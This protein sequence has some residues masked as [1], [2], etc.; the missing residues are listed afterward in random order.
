MVKNKGGEGRQDGLA[1]ARWRQGRC[2]SSTQGDDAST[3]A[4]QS[5]DVPDGQ[6]VGSLSERCAG[7][8]SWQ[9]SNDVDIWRDKS[10][11]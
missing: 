6:L 7:R 11:C 9:G 10:T 3:G 8:Q 5:S 1:N 2:C 4:S